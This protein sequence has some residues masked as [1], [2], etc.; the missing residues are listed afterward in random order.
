M[1]RGRI[2]FERELTERLHALAPRPRPGNLDRA[3]ARVSLRSQRGVWSAR[4]TS[5]RGSANLGRVA[6]A[7]VVTAIA[8]IAGVTIGQV[9]PPVGSAPSPSGSQSSAPSP[10]DSP[11]VPDA[12]PSETA[13][14]SVTQS[15][16]EHGIRLTATLD[17]DS[18]S[19]GQRLWADA[20]VENLGPD[21]VWWQYHGDCLWP[22]DVTVRPTVPTPIA[23]GRDD[24][25]GELGVFKGTLIADE[26]P[27]SPDRRRS[28]VA[29]ERVESGGIGC[30]MTL[31]N[32][33]L[34]AGASA[35]H[36]AAWETDDFMG[37][38]P[39]PGRY[40]VEVTFEFW[41]GAAPESPPDTEPRTVSVQLPLVVE[42]LIA[43]WISPGVA[44]DAL[45]S[46]DRFVTLL[47]QYPRELW[48]GGDMAFQDDRWIAT[49]DFAETVTDLVPV[50]TLVGVVDAR[51]G[52][53][54]DVRVDEPQSD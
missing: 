53:V 17:R 41:R 35:G 37:L 32:A 38:P 3:L 9:G 33:E 54:L 30:F 31:D 15:T 24:W 39:V 50:A 26:Q 51:T 12:S 25:P 52:T 40:T 42:G 13:D 10:S 6:A 36:R 20:T 19:F 34:P 46:D 49:H 4:L 1:N 43:D 16:E 27:I 29:E 2:D 22:A 5:A 48:R 14:G 18:T 8:L 45:L 28:F 7:V 21:S 47:A 44:I 11:S 23:E